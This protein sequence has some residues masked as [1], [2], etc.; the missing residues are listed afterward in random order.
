MPRSVDTLVYRI[1]PVVKL[2]W[3]TWDDQYVVFDETSGQTH[4]IEAANAL[5]LD[6]LDSHALSFDALL[7]ELGMFSETIKDVN[8]SDWLTSVVT[9]LQASGLVEVTTQ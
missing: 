2:H 5:V 3:A 7:N 6:L 9:E 1:R 4:L 8:I